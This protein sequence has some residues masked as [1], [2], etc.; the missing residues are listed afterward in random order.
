VKAGQNLRDEANLKRRHPF[1]SYPLTQLSIILWI[2][3]WVETLKTRILTCL[4]NLCSTN[5]TSMSV[6]LSEV[7]KDFILH[8]RRAVFFELRMN[9]YRNNGI[10]ARWQ[11]WLF[12]LTRLCSFLWKVT[13]KLSKSW[14][15]TLSHL[16]E[17]KSCVRVDYNGLKQCKQLYRLIVC[18]LKC[19]NFP[20]G[21][22]KEFRK[23][24]CSF[25]V[26]VVKKLEI[27]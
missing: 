16:E 20:A 27:Y 21:H 17:F 19:P 18:F 3:T 15:T 11:L 26:K 8:H 10:R 25:S 1:I 24:S 14:I 7:S 4:L 9:I 23:S 12:G 22:I 13:K 6:G 2:Q 5:R